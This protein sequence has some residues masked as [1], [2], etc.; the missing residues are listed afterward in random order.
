M[1]NTIFLVQLQTVIRE[2][3]F[4]VYVMGPTLSLKA[5]S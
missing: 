4:P 1:A 2:L 5:Y 3:E